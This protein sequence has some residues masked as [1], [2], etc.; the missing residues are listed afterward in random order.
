MMNICEFIY[1]DEFDSQ[2]NEKMLLYMH[3]TKFEALIFIS[4]VFSV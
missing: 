2:D 4:Y 1:Y 3:W